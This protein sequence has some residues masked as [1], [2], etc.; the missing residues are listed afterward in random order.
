MNNKFNNY[1][2][3]NEYLDKINKELSNHAGRIIGEVME[4]QMYPGRSYLFFKIKDKDVDNPAILTCMMWKRD[5]EINGLDLKDGLEIIV[6]G[7]ASIYK[8]LG[9]FSFVPKTIE[10]VGEGALKIAYDKLKEKLLKEGLFDDEQKRPMPLYPNKI[11]LITSKSGAVIADFSTNIGK[12][13][14]KI[15]FIDSRVEGQL[16]T[17]ELLNSIRTFRDKDIDVLVIIR[18]GGSME[19]FLP[20]NNEILVR[21]VATFPVPVLAG[22]GHEKDV[23]L[24]ALA[25]DMMVS[26]PTAVANALNESWE[27]A[28]SIVSLSEQSIFA[29]FKD[30]IQI[31]KDF[32]RD[33]LDVMKNK[34]Q[35][36]FN[37]FSL[38]QEAL[39]IGVKTIKDQIIDINRR[40]QGALVPVMRK[41]SYSI[42]NVRN[43]LSDDITR[44]VFKKFSDSKKKVDEVLISYEKQITNNDPKRQLKLGYS[45]VMKNGKIL[46]TT[47][48]L[49]NGDIVNVGLSEGSFDSEV[50]I[51]NSK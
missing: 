6:S 34:F 35:K 15:S 9:R 32:I 33:S 40:I 39:K 41:M 28:E 50:K 37:D 4:V 29:K 2:S 25:S 23:S 47:S 7:S 51:I 48:G 36:I 30:T 19:S 3:I 45:I 16:A 44:E 38:A 49:H 11:G 14:Y 31:N 13:G 8:P 26:T 18:G 24:L 10:L 20:F 17:E 46:K 1:V 42:T 27:R 5:Y 22:I 12:F 43:N 21:E